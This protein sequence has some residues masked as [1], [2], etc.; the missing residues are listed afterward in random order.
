MPRAHGLALRQQIID[1]HRQ[2]HHAVAISQQLAVSLNT[3]RR[4]VRRYKA[5]PTDALQPAYAI[6]C[7]PSTPR[8]VPHLLRAGRWLK[9]RHPQ[10]GAPLI[11]QYLLERYA[12][13]PVP[14][15]RT[16]QRHFRHCGLTPPRQQVAPGGIGRAKAPHNIWQVDA[17]ERLRLADGQAACYLTIADEHSG[18]CL[19]TLVFPPRPH[20]SSAPG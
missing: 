14:A 10:W 6:R 20:Q 7:G 15:V 9:R 19:Q 5:D 16:L 11:R 18:A 12:A 1:L 4:L 13:Q 8:S 2:H 17:K 3:V